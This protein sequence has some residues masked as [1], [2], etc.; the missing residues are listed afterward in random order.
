ML[1]CKC[2]LPEHL[3]I[4]FLLPKLSSMHLELCNADKKGNTSSQGSQISREQNQIFFLDQQLWSGHE[5]S[6]LGARF[7]SSLD[8]SKGWMDGLVL[9]HGD[10]PL[11]KCPPIK[12]RFPP[13][14]QLAPSLK[15]PSPGWIEGA[16]SLGERSEGS[17][18]FCLGLKGRAFFCQFLSCSSKSIMIKK[19][20]FSGYFFF[21]FFFALVNSFT[22]EDTHPEERFLVNSSPRHGAMLLEISSLNTQT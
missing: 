20:T 1:V 17:S 3:G 18:S 21:S 11:F 22:V 16:F 8:L 5:F 2:T 6:E 15:K 19:G 4:I 9:R 14:K 12:N 10:P 7:Q 13:W